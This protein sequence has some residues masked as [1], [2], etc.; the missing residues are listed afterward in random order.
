MRVENRRF[1][2]LTP[3][4]K[5][6]LRAEIDSITDRGTIHWES[7]FLTAW[8]SNFVE[9]NPGN[10]YTYGQQALLMVSTVYPIDALK[11][12]LDN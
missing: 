9:S 5:T 10:A 4:E 3:E 6:Q 1:Y 2:D 7:P 12:L 8:A 11:S